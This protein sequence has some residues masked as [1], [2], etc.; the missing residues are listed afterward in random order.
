MAGSGRELTALASSY[1]AEPPTAPLIRMKR[2]LDVITAIAMVFLLAPVMVGIAVAI[3]LETKGSP[4]YLDCR[5]G[6]SGSAFKMMKFRTMYCDAA[7]RRS[8]LSASSIADPPLFKVRDDPRVTRVGKFLRRWSLDEIPQLINVIAGQ[9]SLVGPRPL[10][11]QEADA[12][13]DRGCH[14][15][16][17]RP[18]IT[19]PWQVSGR[20]EV[21]TEDLVRLD[22]A[23][24]DNWTLRRDLRL[25]V[26]TLP[27]V[28]SGKG[29]F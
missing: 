29:A 10:I 13:G 8:D 26:R 14:R 20:A 27:A 5:R 3:S 12:L 2:V 19:G 11:V 7:A 22:N 25:I 24:V 16:A 28:I 17:M 15:M 23:Y 9:M 1:E 6:R 21:S 4:I 18:G